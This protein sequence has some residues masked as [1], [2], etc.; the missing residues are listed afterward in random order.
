M[1]QATEGTAERISRGVYRTVLAIVLSTVVILVL[2]SGGFVIWPLEMLFFLVAGWVF[3]LVRV[4]P[5]ITLNIGSLLTGVLA[6]MLFGI[7]MHLALGWVYR[8]TTPAGE[9][10]LR[11]WRLLRTA[12]LASLVLLAFAAG[13][14]AIGVVHQ[15]VWLVLE[16]GPLTKGG[17]EVAARIKSQNNMKLVALALHNHHAT[18]S[19]FPPGY[20]VDVLG[21]PLHGWQTHLLPYLEQDNLF[22]QIQL[23]RPWDD[24]AN[25]A[26]F[27]REIREYTLPNFGPQSDAEGY[28]LSH[29]AGNSHAFPGSKKKG[30]RFSDFKN[31][32]S[33]TI[34]FGEVSAGF[35]PWG[36]PLNI[37]DAARGLGS[38]VDKFG[39]PW[40]GGQTRFA[41]GDGSVRSV[42]PNISPAVL[43]ALATPAGR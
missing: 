17:R 29:Y 26:A 15:I 36:H 35:R 21:E 24:Q 3:F 16:P 30:L 10:S 9:G 8:A 14:A 6:L 38:A 37:R 11:R 20:T 40:P 13:I 33:N 31:G 4:G 1:S 22:N 34:L 12:G 41:L 5:Q 27:C 2:L 39:G 32:V 19:Y 42:S 25:H 23:D 28:S 18:L 7:S 43:K